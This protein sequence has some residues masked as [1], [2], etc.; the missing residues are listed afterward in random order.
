MNCNLVLLEDGR[1]GCANAGC[2]EPPL[3]AR[4]PIEK[5]R[6]NCTGTEARSRGLGDSIAKVTTALGIKPC[7]GCK[8]RQ[9]L[10]NKLVPYKQD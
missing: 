5:V 10:L 9:A 1:Y 6:R 2:K 3:P 7:G 8:E 4:V